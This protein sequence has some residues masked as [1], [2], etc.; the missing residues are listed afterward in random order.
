MVRDHQPAAGVEELAPV[1]GPFD[2]PVD[3]RTGGQE[4][5]AAAEAGMAIGLRR[6]EHH[7][8]RR[9]A[10]GIQRLGACHHRDPL[11]TRRA[12]DPFG[13]RDQ[14]QALRAAAAMCHLDRELLDRALRVDAPR[15]L[16]QQLVGLMADLRAAG[17]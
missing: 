4:R 9:A 7:R 6:T 16:D 13:H 5:G 2:R 15:G 1:T 8:A 10:A 14:P 3:A 12:E 11:G 17:W